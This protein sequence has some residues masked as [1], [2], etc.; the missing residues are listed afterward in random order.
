L[1]ATAAAHFTT[2]DQTAARFGVHE[3]VLSGDGAV[4]N[5]F[6]TLATVAFTPPSGQANA[7]EAQAFY[8]GDS[9]WRARVYASEVGAWHWASSCA[10]DPALDGRSGTFTVAES[11]LRGRLLPHPRNPR[12]WCTEDGRWFLNLNDTAYFLLCAHD[13]DGHP[14]P[15]EDVH[16]YVRE[17]TSRGITSFRSFIANGATPFNGPGGSDRHRWH[18]LFAD[19]AMTRPDLE[20]LRVAD[21]RLRWLLEEYADVYLQFILFPLG[22]P[23]RTDEAVWTTMTAA[24]K[25][26]IL[27]YLVARF[28]AYPQVFWLIVNDA[29]FGPETL[30]PRPDD[31]HGTPRELTFPN[32]CAMA[33]EVGTFLQAN[34][35]W[36]HP[37]SAGPARGAAFDFD[38][39]AWATYVHLEESYDLAARRYE[40]YHAL[41]KPVFLGE[42]RYEQ[43]HPQT[44]DPRDMRYFQ[45]RLFWAWLLA[46]G[47]ANYGGRWW[48][49][50][51]Y[52]QTGRRPAPSIH[53]RDFTYTAPLTGLDSVKAIRDYFEARRIELSDFAP[54]HGLA[55]DLDGAEPVAQ[56]KVMRRQQ[57]E[58]LVYHPSAGASGREARPAAGRAAR[59]RLDLSAARGTLVP[60]WYRADDGASQNGPPVVAGAL[61]EFTSPWPGQDVVLRLARPADTAATRPGADV[62]VPATVPTVGA[63]RSAPPYP[64]SPVISRLEWAPPAS[65][66]RR[67]RGSDNWPLTWADD[68]ALYTAYGDGNGFEPF[69]PEK[70]SLGLARVTGGPGDLHGTNLRAPSAEARGDGAK[71]RKASGIL[72]VDGA[73]YLLVR[74]AGNAQLGWSADHGATWTWADWRWTTSFGCPTFVQFGANYAGARDGFVYLVSPDS[75]SA[76]TPADRM[77]L[78]RVPK[79]RLRERD[80]YEFLRGL[81][82]DGQPEW[83]PRIE[84]RGAAFTHPGRCYRS[85][86]TY[87]A[88][89]QRYLW[90]QILPASQHPQ[91]PRFQGGF[92]VYDAPEPWG[93]WTT[94]FFTEDWDVGPGETAS[95]PTKWQS[96]DGRALHLVFS[97]EDCFSVRGCT[98][99]TGRQ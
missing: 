78:A 19:E 93:P 24:Q 36:R 11:R 90:V 4:A 7:K 8:D 47:S 46:G 32:N 80:A 38:T 34:D 97:G 99:E 67:A 1:A 27:R 13:G 2:G 68:D 77:V 23:W 6:D 96:A 50:Q 16:A 66:V 26:R 48:T 3:I 70:L 49:V 69:T 41:G 42:D 74:N 83:T 88:A 54:C 72:C 44:H 73:L 55:L 12:Q 95:F 14:V 63:R 51:P 30:R 15:D 39:E 92:G 40:Q 52:T 59:L 57:E 31:A 5:P 87:N 89:R 56:P 81:T 79:D 94:V 86:I 22:K 98:V 10:A 84:A 45:R 76:Y 9:T 17:A 62:A 43:D 37:I 53:H 58:F 85:G 33:R 29:H 21:Q 28:A 71:G 75:D 18:D 82:P 35:P 61:V 20:H 60:E 91:G 64:P 65:I 25:E